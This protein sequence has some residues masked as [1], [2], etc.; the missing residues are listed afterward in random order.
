M[1][2]LEMVKNTTA[3][4]RQVQARLEKELFSEEYMGGTDV[5][6][7]RLPNKKSLIEKNGKH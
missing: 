2:E 6:Q 7:A 4:A 1:P 3:L 5:S